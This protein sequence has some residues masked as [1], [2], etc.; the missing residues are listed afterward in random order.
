MIKKLKASLEQRITKQ[1]QIKK[2]ERH[3]SEM[4][5]GEQFVYNHEDIIT[6]IIMQCRVSTPRATEF[7]SG[8]G[9]NQHN[10]TITKE[11]SKLTKVIKIFLNE[12]VSL[13]HSVLTCYKI[14]L[15]ITEHKLA[16]E[17]DKKGDTDRNTNE[18]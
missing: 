7:R 10:I 12:K 14:D 3:G 2:H 16:I 13:Q 11:Q 18:K 9:F 8:L 1:Q 15:F 5:K 6:I 4:I 17:I